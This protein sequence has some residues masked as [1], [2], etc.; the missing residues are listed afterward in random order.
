MKIIEQIGEQSNKVLFQYNLVKQ[1]FEYLTEA[2]QKIWELDKSQVEQEP[3]RLLATVVEEDRAAVLRC[4][5]RLL[6]GEHV[7]ET[8]L[9]F[10]GKRK[11]FVRFDVYPIRDDKGDIVAVAGM[12]EDAT[13]HRQYLDY[14]I[15]F[16]NRKNSALEM[17][18]HDLR[19]PLA[20]VKSV[21]E[22]LRSD[23]E[24]NRHEEINA[25]TDIIEKVCVSCTNLINDLLSEEHLRSPEVFVNKTRGD[26]YVQIRE[27]VEFY[28]KSPLV[29]QRFELTL[30]EEP[31]VI[32]VDQI[33]FSQVL[34]NLISNS[35]K[36]TPAD[37]FISI[38]AQREGDEV[39]LVHY[40]NGIGIPEHLQAGVFDRYVNVGRR[41]LNGE[42]TRGLGMSIARELVELHGGSISVQSN[43]NEGTT[44]TI[45]IPLSDD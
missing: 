24:D 18:S 39:V 30:P 42:E 34:N 9:I 31:L 40:D 44:F 26:L 10:Q 2:F 6:Q 5:H 12:A 27:V 43:E 11:Y 28:Q 14:L 35:I 21:A 25:Y 8:V 23:L 3:Q 41:G 29:Q 45:R 13:R 36:F 22:L 38:S 20:V 32:A 17:V 33:K 19:G 1:Q 37:G 4:W 16:G 7:E 15:E